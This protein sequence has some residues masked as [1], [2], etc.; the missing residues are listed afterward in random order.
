MHFILFAYDKLSFGM[1]RSKGLNILK[2]F[3]TT[4][5]NG[6]WINYTYFWINYILALNGISCFIV[7][8]PG[9]ILFWSFNK[10]KQYLINVFIFSYLITLW[11]WFF[12]YLMDIKLFLLWI[13][14]LDSLSIFCNGFMFFF[15]IW[16][17]RLIF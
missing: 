5:P 17:K 16:M 10:L 8:L 7:I 13:A 4:L 12:I 11:D 3:H 1:I 9:F 15:S 14:Y 2:T 6:F